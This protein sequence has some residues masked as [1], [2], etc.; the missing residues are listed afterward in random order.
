MNDG[1]YVVFSAT[2]SKM[3]R[4]IRLATRN[5]YNHVSISFDAD[6]HQLYSFAR[7]HYSTPLYGGLIRESI[8]R[9][10]PDFGNAR[11]KIC[12]LP[13]DAPQ[14]HHIVNELEG[15]WSERELYIYNTF[16]AI[17][18]VLHRSPTIPKSYTCVSFV[19]DILA[20]SNLADPA[21]AVHPSI[22]KLEHYLTDYV[23]YE[24][25]ALP[26]SARGEWGDDDF[27]AE[28]TRFYRAYTT[29][30]HFGRLTKR[31]LFGVT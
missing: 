28:T 10:G 9:Y 2:P 23:I 12:R 25:S 26:F 14:F 17:T 7:Y 6:I 5:S 19:I 1:I 18:T 30:R 13:V 15:M 20:R 27:L 4:L 24:G 3:G 21:T 22:R 16:A 31:A 29:A 8:L 11:V